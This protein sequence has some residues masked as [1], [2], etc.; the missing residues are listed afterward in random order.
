MSNP[1]STSVM[2]FSRGLRLS[3]Q[4]LLMGFFLASPA[5]ASEEPVRPSILIRGSGLEPNVSIELRFPADIIPLDEVG[6]REPNRLLTI[7]PAW[8]GELHWRSPRL[9]RF[10]PGAPP[11]FQTPYQLR[12]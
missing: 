11:E 2:L 10:V 8:E 5:V 3:W 9:A 6:R 12:I 4:S 7:T 1:G